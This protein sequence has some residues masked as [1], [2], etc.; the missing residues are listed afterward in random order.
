MER[1]EFKSNIEYVIQQR[2]DAIKR[3]EPRLHP[4]WALVRNE[5]GLITVSH[6]ESVLGFE[7]IESDS[8][9][10]PPE[11]KDLYRKLLLDGYYVVVIIPESAYL[12]TMARI[13]MSGSP[14]PLIL[15]Y[16]ATG[17]IKVPRSS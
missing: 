12:I 3:S 6:G 11:R 17:I 8:S 10:A 2:L 15:C 14:Y 7:L 4:E 16:G 9:W 1:S 5:W 13:M